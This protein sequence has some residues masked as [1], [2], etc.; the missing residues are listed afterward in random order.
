MKKTSLSALAFT[1]AL[2]MVLAGCS[3]KQNTIV[4]GSKN[5]T[6]NIVLGEMVA[7][8]IE[9]QTDLKVERKPNLG[10]TD[11]TLK[12]IT[13]GDIDM[14][15]E[16]DGTVYSSYLKIQDPVTDPPAVFDMVN[17]K[18]QKEM[19]LKLTKPL[20]FNNTFTIA[21]PSEIAKANNLVTYSDLAKVSDQFVFG[22]DPEFM[23]REPDGWNSLKEK[24]GFNFKKE[25]TLDSG[26]RY[27]SIQANEMQV[28]NAFATD[29]QLK[30]FNMTVL[31]DDL[32][33]FPPYNAAPIVRM[34]TLE[35]YPELEGVLNQLAG[36]LT[37]ADMQELNYL[38]DDKKETEEKVAKDFL[39]SKG[40]L[41]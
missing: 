30:T 10:A 11:I 8:L 21:M 25:I 19:K 39:T 4:V 24:Y 23:N 12:A 3:S 20:G 40:L 36:L 41:K 27:K 5:F 7:Q 6:E 16:Y 34:E 29:G 15:L 18:L 33:F 28:T 38:V 9:N 26:L 37:D 22:A 14:Y 35:K 1:L 31:K 32:N 13:S 2:V 17:E